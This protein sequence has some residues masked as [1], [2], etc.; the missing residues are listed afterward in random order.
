MTWPAPVTLTGAIGGVRPLT[1][2]DAP[3]LAE[4]SAEANLWRLWYTS[5]PAPDAVSEEIDRRLAL[6]SAGQMTAFTIADAN[7]S[8][9]G[10]TTY[11]RPDESNLRL[12]IGSTWYR[13]SVQR[14]GLNTQVKLLMLAHAFE[15]LKCNCVEFRTHAMNTQSRRAIE[16][17]G[18]KLDGVLRAQQILANGTLR[19]TACYSIIA[20]EWPVVRAHLGWQLETPRP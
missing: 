17:L 14:T 12:E 2:E 1:Q 13:K 4:C 3:A 9:V 8:A 11:M 10:M 18:A 6:Q 20:P 15:T 19:D 7:G 16:R 5:V